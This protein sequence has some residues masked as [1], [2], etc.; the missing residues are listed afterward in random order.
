MLKSIKAANRRQ[1]RTQKM[2]EGERRRAQRKAAKEVRRQ[3][4]Q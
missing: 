4:E 2:N 3:Q 1:K